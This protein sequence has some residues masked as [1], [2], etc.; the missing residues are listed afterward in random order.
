MFSS[1]FA[2]DT[3]MEPDEEFDTLEERTRSLVFQYDSSNDAKFWR[4]SLAQQAVL[5]YLKC[6]KSC[7]RRVNNSSPEILRT[8][9]PNL[10]R[11]CKSDG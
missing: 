1:M 8:C 2:A 9:L 11:H 4:V 7:I 10:G 5:L 6:Y 3:D